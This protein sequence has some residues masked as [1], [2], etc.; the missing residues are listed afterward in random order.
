MTVESWFQCIGNCE[1]K[2]SIFDVIYKCP[3]CGGLLEVVHDL[4]ALQKKD[5]STWQNLF[6]QRGSNRIGANSS[7]VWSKKE[8]VLPTIEEANIVSM[9]EGNNPLLSTPRLADSWGLSN[10]W[11]KQCGTTHTGSFKDLGMT[12][13]VS[14]VKQ[15]ISQGGPIQA[16]ACA[17]T[18]DTSAALSA[19]G[20]AAGIPTIVFLPANKIS[21][22]QLVQPLANGALVLALDT[23]FDG[24]MEVVVECTQTSGIYLANSM[25]SLRVEGQKT[26]AFEII[27]QLGWKAP[28]WIVIPGGN[29][30]NVSALGKGLRL[31]LDLG[32]LQKKPRIL[33]A[34]AE[35]ANP[36]YLSYQNNFNDFEAQTAD[37]TLASAIRIGS[38]VSVDK[39]IKELRFF[40]GAVEQT[41]EQELVEAMAAA[42]REGMFTCPQTGVA[43]GALKKAIQSGVV[44]QDA[45]VALVS[46]A[47]GLKFSESKTAYHMDELKDLKAHQ[48]NSPRPV[49]ANISEVRNEIERYIDSLGTA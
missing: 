15:I 14:V 49:S 2:H 45:S 47:H 21:P 16:V 41:S 26:V 9:G 27:Q 3:K 39:A 42:D 6:D 44:E 11:I 8:W 24:C 34:Q 22:A 19:Y 25:N 13:L 48:A 1:G 37:P 31:M 4:N 7:G 40:H 30:G 38:P 46:T 35:A 43:L 20:A 33:V 32:V 5:A 28:D 18:G 17:S 12:A 29:L 36:L 10:L 23:D